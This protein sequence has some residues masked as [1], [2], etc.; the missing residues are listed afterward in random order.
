MF[1]SISERLNLYSQGLLGLRRTETF[2]TVPH[3]RQ[4]QSKLLRQCTVLYFKMPREGW[5]VY[6][7]NPGQTIQTSLWSRPTLW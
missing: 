7:Q 1:H 5:N 4:S 2:Q 3:T 6:S